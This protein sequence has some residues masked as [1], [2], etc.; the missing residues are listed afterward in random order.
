MHARAALTEAETIKLRH[1]VHM[2]MG[3]ASFV[4]LLL[5]VAAHATG[6]LSQG[7]TT[8]DSS[9]TVGA[10]VSFHTGSKNVVE[11]S[12]VS[13]VSSLVGITANKPLVA[14]GDDTKQ[15]QVVIGGQTPAIVSDI[16]G[17]IKIGDKITASPLQGVGMK[18]ATSTEIVGTAEGNLA[19]SHTTLQTVTDKSGKQTQVHVGVIEVQVNVSYYVVDSSKLNGIV[20][21]FLVNVGSSVAGKDVSPVRVLIGFT[22]LLVGFIIA[23]ILLQAG[24]RS[25]II[26]IGRNPL[27]QGVLRRSLVDVLVTAVGVLGLTVIAF[28]LVLT[29]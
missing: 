20:P 28:Y 2:L 12:T 13:S 17:P 29:F 3:G 18:A 16:N 1:T 23:G 10:L 14:L 11:K 25:G 19:D 27:A 26:A 5:P 15:V 7:L 8:T 21:T 9:L 4:Y 22:R 24:V 6:A